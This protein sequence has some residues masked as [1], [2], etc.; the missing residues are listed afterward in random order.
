MA[1]AGIDADIRKVRLHEK[2]FTSLIVIDPEGKI[3]SCVDKPWNVG[4][5]L[6]QREYFQITLQQGRT[7]ISDSILT[8]DKTITVVVSTPIRN[9]AGNIVGVL[10]GA[11]DVHHPNFKA[12][13]LDTGIGAPGYACLVDRQGIVLA[14]PETKRSLEQENFAPYGV[15]REVLAGKT[16]AAVYTFEGTEMLAAYV[17]VEPSG[18]GVIVQQPLAAATARAITLRRFLLTVALV[19][20]VIAGFLGILL[21]RW[22]SAPLGADA[23]NGSPTGTEGRL[24]L[25]EESERKW[26]R[27]LGPDPGRG[28]VPGHCHHR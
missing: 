5:S 6:A 26:K 14:H 25:A 27:P 15:V 2:T 12:V 13:I 1:P 8:L 3:L 9:D 24:L 23:A 11:F 21:F 4:K 19:D 28:I 16:G 10:A 17:P 7:Y 20:V 22:I 18:W